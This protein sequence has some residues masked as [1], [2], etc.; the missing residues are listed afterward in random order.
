MNLT[1]VSIGRY[2]GSL[3]IP[4]P[5]YSHTEGWRSLFG[6]DNTNMTRLRYIT[7]RYNSA[8]TNAI[9]LYPA[10]DHLL[11][12]DSYYLR[13]AQEV[14]LL[15]S[16]YE[17]GWMLG[18]SIWYE[19]KTQLR[20]SVCYYDTMSVREFQGKRWRKTNL[21]HGRIPVSG[22][23]AC[24]ILPLRAWQ[25][26]DGFVVRTN[27]YEMMTS[28]CIDGNGL[29]LKSVLDCDVRLWRTRADNP[30]IP[31]YPPWKRLVVSAGEWR[32]KMGIR[33]GPLSALKSRRD[34]RS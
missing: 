1:A 28:R 13:F 10:T 16:H 18:A 4:I 34:S 19:A 12:I 17:P 11:I 14:A 9:Q 7:D 3:S 20:T 27:P 25:K 30:D 22:V 29:G 5:F 15:V 32:R 31:I 6:R 23:G 2:P 8:I 24:W 21:P 33:S 26:S